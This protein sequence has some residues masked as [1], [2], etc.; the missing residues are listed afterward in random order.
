LGTPAFARL[1]GR[2][3]RCKLAFSLLGESH[4]ALGADRSHWK[5]QFFDVTGQTEQAIATCEAQ[6]AHYLAAWCRWQLGTATSIAQADEHFRSIGAVAA[7]NH[8]RRNLKNSE[9]ALQLE[10]VPR[11]PNSFSRNHP[12][13]LTRKEQIVLS[14]MIEGASNASI[15]RALSRSVRTVEN[16]VSAILGKLNASNRAEVIVRVQGEPWLLD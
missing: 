2:G 15:A 11:G 4:D 3:T 5:W 10:P 13:G 9:L 7:Q 12:Y 16:H 6:S 8:L 14:H 1:F